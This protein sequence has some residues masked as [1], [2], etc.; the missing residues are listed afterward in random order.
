M[1]IFEKMSVVVTPLRLVLLA[2]FVT[3]L[4]GSLARAQQSTASAKTDS[5]IASPSLSPAQIEN[6]ISKFTA[7]ETRF[8]R[9]LNSYAFKRDALVQEIGMGGQIIGEYHRLSEFTFDDQGNRYEKINFF[10][11]ATFAGMTA[12]D[13]EDS[14]AVDP[15]ALEAAK[16][17]QYSSK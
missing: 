10:P 15:F 5:T 1:R 16:L 7:K 8:R 11:M 9:A 2:V 3:A 12:E 17:S 6:I 14:G 13:L 4:A